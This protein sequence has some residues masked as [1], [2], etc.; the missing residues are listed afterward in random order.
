MAALS[1]VLLS[2]LQ[3]LLLAGATVLMTVAAW[4]YAGTPWGRVLEPLPVAIAFFAVTTGLTAIRFDTYVS[5]PWVPVLWAVP[6][7]CAA[8]AAYRF[9][10]ATMRGEVL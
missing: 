7:V 4:G 10:H 1:L 3:A 2:L 6:V 9:V 8:L 5:L